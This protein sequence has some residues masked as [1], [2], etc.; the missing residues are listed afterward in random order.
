MRFLRSGRSHGQVWPGGGGCC[1]RCAFQ[2][3]VWK[4]CFRDNSQLIA[5]LLEV[6]VRRKSSNNQIIPNVRCG[7]NFAEGMKM[8]RCRLSWQ[9]QC[10]VRVGIVE[11]EILWQVRGIVRL[12]RL[13]GVKVAVPWGLACQLCF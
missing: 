12:R 9:A 10:F 2:G 1:A 6:S 11:V 8:S 4:L 5:I 13:V 3:V 7:A